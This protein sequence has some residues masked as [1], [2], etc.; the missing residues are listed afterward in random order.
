VVTN[1]KHLRV[2]NIVSSI[3]IH[4]FLNGDYHMTSATSIPLALLSIL[5][6]WEAPKS[7]AR[8]EG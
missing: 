1:V 3:S 8:L 6:T 2:L 4:M 5:L 7:E